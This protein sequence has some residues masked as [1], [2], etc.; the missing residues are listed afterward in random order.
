MLP[1]QGNCST[2]IPETLT[3]TLADAA[4]L[5]T[6]KTGQCLVIS[7]WSVFGVAGTRVWLEG[8]YIRMAE[9]RPGAGVPIPELIPVGDSAGQ[10]TSEVYMSN[11]SLQGNGGQQECE[12]CGLRAN[13]ATVYAEGTFVLFCL[14]TRRGS[15]RG[16][17]VLFCP[18]NRK[19]SDR[20]KPHSRIMYFND[21]IHTHSNG[22]TAP[23]RYCFPAH[24]AMLL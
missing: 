8:L 7:D 23:S 18:D 15:D 2:P 17:V 5:Q 13:N 9:S 19:G 12:W 10:A 3:L 1:L 24:F 4:P 20:E 11:V 22:T 16:K 6:L 21:S 14:Y